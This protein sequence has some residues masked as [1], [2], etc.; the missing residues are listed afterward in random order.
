MVLRECGSSSA[1]ATGALFFF[2]LKV[3][4]SGNS[5]FWGGGGTN[6]FCM[7]ASGCR[8]RAR[9]EGISGGSSKLSAVG[10]SASASSGEDLGTA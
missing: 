1:N 2:G 4:E 8:V 7:G 9:Y 5:C 3:G 10:G 6:A